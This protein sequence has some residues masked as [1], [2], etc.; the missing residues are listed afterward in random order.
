MGL[1]PKYRTKGT[2]RSGKEIPVKQ[3]IPMFPKK[4][5]KTHF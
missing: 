5:I 4:I 3:I 1:D 2:Q